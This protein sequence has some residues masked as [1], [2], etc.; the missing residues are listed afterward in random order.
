MPEIWDSCRFYDFYSYPTKTK[1]TSGRSVSTDKSFRLSACG[2][3]TLGPGVRACLTQEFTTPIQNF[4]FWLWGTVCFTANS[5]ML[6]LTQLMCPRFRKKEQRKTNLRCSENTLPKIK[7]IKFEFN[8]P[9]FDS[10]DKPNK[11]I[12]CEIKYWNFYLMIIISLWKIL[13]YTIF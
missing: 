13:N 4:H 7:V 9:S 8:H 3:I 5:T 2:T 1:C 6:I 11:W 12:C 10:F